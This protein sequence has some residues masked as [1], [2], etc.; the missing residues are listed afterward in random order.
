MHT[1]PTIAARRVIHRGKKFDFEQVDVAMPSGGVVQREMVRHP[2]AVV[3]VPRMDDGRL[4]L[5]RVYRFALERWSIECCAGTLE[6][7][8][9]PAVCASRELIEE[10]GYQAARVSPLGSYD[11]T[12]GL[13]SERMHAY[14]ADGLAYVG[15][16]LEPDEAIEVLLTPPR[17]ALAMID[18]GRLCDGKSMVAL[19][20]AQRRG[21][22]GV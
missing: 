19:L 18:D 3:V 10:T 15:Q 9:D 20:V 13:T 5:I 8:E 7:G 16:R 4:V 22:L 11:T 17:E 2:G 6:I 12:P 1:H 21:L 14:F